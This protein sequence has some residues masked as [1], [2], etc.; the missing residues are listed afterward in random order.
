MKLLVLIVSYNMETWIDKCLGSLDLSVYDVLVIDNAS[1]DKTCEIIEKKYPKI[2]LI[3][4]NTNLGFGA[5]NN[6][7][8]KYFLSKDYDFLFLLNQ[9]AWINE[10]TISNLIDCISIDP[11]IM[12]LS[13]IH[14]NVNGVLERHFEMFVN[15]FFDNLI[16]NERICYVP[17]VNAAAWLMTKECL[18]HVGFFDPM[19]YH[20]GEDDNYSQRV[21]YHGY[22]MAV[23][24]SSIIIHDCPQNF[25]N[26]NRYRDLKSFERHIKIFIGNINYSFFTRFLS[27]FLSL[28]WLLIKSIF[29]F[30]FNYIKKWISFLYCLLINF[31]VIKESYI[32]NRNKPLLEKI[33]I[34]E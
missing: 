6:I 33:Y 5:A 4:N 3:T 7:G 30:R 20:Y 28:F 29:L 11:K 1:S 12:I 10:N 16:L 8:F 24:K 26:F 2:H 31:S 27:V 15:Q 22:K 13:P 34:V 23:C 21:E 14:L 18:L 17:F 9:D 19:F 32:R 25:L